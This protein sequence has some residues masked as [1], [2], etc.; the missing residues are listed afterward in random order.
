MEKSSGLY[1]L[2]YDF[3]EARIRFGFYRYGDCLPSI[4]HICGTFHLGRATVR[5]AL[6]LL[7][8]DGYIDNRER[9]AARV[10]YEADRGRYAENAWDY[11]MPRKDG[12]GEMREAGR[13]LIQPLWEAG[14]RRWDR[15]RWEFYCR[16]LSGIL[17]GDPPP[18]MELYLL[19]LMELDNQLFLNLYWEVLRYIRMP[20]LVDRGKM[21]SLITPDTIREG[22]DSGDVVAWMNRAVWDVYVPLEEG[23]FSFIHRETA[24][25]GAEE[26]EAI[27]F[28][29]NIYRNRPQMRYT[30]ASI[31]IRKILYGVYPVGS[32]LPSLP[33]LAERYGAS[34]TTVRRTLALLEEMGVTESFQGKGTLV[35]MKR[36]RLDLEKSEIREGLRLHRESLQFLRL[37][38][39]G[40]AL[41]TLE[42]ASAGKRAALEGKL[43]G[44]LEQGNSYHCFE[45]MLMFIR[46]ECPL[47]MVQEC[48]ARIAELVAWGYPFARLLLPE[49]ELGNAYALRVER[50]ADCLCREEFEGFCNQWTAL[51]EQEEE[52]ISELGAQADGC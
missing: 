17:P 50:M 16:N 39:R 18:S 51:L 10:V 22:L 28:Q 25:R 46:E 27:P 15:N 30:L 14:A 7:E 31:L 2:V 8:T 26:I 48:Y 35:C 43:R 4:S 29:W 1:L 52:K 34:L 9:R 49:G 12:L 19:A 44:M 40:V 32:Y 5:A 45:I 20:S 37:T 36:K 3:Y 33:E 38:I 11:Y 41:F 13:L 24:A 6:A 42:R 23:L 47:A 21:K